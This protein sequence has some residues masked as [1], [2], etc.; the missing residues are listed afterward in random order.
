[1]AGGT[2]ESSERA[3]SG[4]AMQANAQTTATRNKRADI[5]ASSNQKRCTA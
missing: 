5:D 2:F 1:L 4:A 3:V